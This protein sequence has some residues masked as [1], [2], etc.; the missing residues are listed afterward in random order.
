[1]AE[2][3]SRKEG[4]REENR[5]EERREGSPGR[6]FILSR[7]TWAKAETYKGKTESRGGEEME[8]EV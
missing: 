2:G 1:M 7:T 3:E 8:Q 5:K 4:K 6:N